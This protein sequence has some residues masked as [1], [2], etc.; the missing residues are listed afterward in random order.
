[1]AAG[2]SDRNEIFRLVMTGSI[3]RQRSGSTTKQDPLGAGA[4]ARAAELGSR[5][6]DR[7]DR[8]EDPPGGD[9]DRVLEPVIECRHHGVLLSSYVLH[10]AAR[11]SWNF[12]RQPYR[13]T[14]KG[15]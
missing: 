6:A 5:L 4:A 2:G 13:L 1:M 8:R 9:I 10:L 3:G 7:L 11:P 14:L 15:N 12:G